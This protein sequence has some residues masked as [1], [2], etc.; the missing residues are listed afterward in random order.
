M[1]RAEI[2]LLLNFV[3]VLLSVAV[4]C[5]AASRGH[6]VLVLFAALGGAWHS[7]LLQRLGRRP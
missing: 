6:L 4:M 7:T 3:G 5:A 2:T 1:S